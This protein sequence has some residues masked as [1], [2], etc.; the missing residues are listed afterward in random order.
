MMNIVK[1]TLKNPTGDNLNCK[2]NSA[3]FL[4]EF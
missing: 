1:T 4:A 2:K 3:K